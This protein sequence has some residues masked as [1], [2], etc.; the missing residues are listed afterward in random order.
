M[1][2][3]SARGLRSVRPA[4]AWRGGEMTDPAPLPRGRIAVK[5]AVATSSWWAVRLIVLAAG[6]YLVARLLALLSVVTVPLIMALLLTALLAPVRDLI[7]RAGLHRLPASVLTVLVALAVLGGLLTLMGMQVSSG[8]GRLVNDAQSTLNDVQR[9]FSHGFFGLG[10]VQFSSVQDRITSWLDQHRN[11]LISA[12]YAGVNITVRVVVG[13][14]LAALLTV[15]LL[16]DG[17][18]LWGS[19]SNGAGARWSAKLD[20]AGRAAWR[21]LS[22]YVHGTL[23]IA[24]FHGIVIG[25]TL[26]LLGVPLAGVLALAV[27][28]GSFVPIVGALVA[29]GAAVLV[30]L[31]TRGLVDAGVVLAVLIAANQV[32]AHVLQPV[33]MRRFVR[34]HPAVTVVAITAFGEVWG[35]VGALIA[36]PVCS[37]AARATPVLLGSTEVD[38][39]GETHPAGPAADG[40]AQDRRADDLAESRHLDDVGDPAGRDVGDAAG[41]EGAPPADMS[42]AGHG[43]PAPPPRPGRDTDR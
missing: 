12:A 42:R 24:T 4:G 21:S 32:E 9:T 18:R 8:A 31:A 14:V 33:V 41:S 37:V 40:G 5:D 15:L 39:R 20:G 6:A 35:V 27:F 36:V 11:Q 2:T 13:T 16:W 19:V 7:E 10:S 34:L 22:G 28:V 1:R 17:D 26:V 29:G 38:D 23:V 30:T 25:T 3:R 43:T